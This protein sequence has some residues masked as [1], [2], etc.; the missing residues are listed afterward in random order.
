MVFWL[1][2]ERKGRSDTILNWKKE[3]LQHVNNFN[4][5][6]RKQISGFSFRHYLSIS[7][8]SFATSFCGL[9][10]FF[11]FLYARFVIKTPFL[12]F[13]KETFFGQFSFKVTNRLFYLIVL[14]NNFHILLTSWGSFKTPLPGKFLCQVELQVIETSGMLYLNNIFLLDSD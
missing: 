4:P 12:D 7:S 2:P 10:L 9:G 11:L 5:K 8:Y 1:V 13:W 6:G 3:Q 14:Y